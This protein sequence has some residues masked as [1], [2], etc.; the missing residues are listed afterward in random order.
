MH[1]EVSADTVTGRPT[2]A[3]LPAD[4]ARWGERERNYTRNFIRAQM[5]VRCSPS[6]PRSPEV[7]TQ[8]KQMETRSG[9][10][11]HCWTT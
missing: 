2:S 9:Q 6:F 1:A 3:G 8:D 7:L 5:E 4:V 10:S 11:A